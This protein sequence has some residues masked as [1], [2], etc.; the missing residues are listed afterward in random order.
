MG[1]FMKEQFW[2]WL[3]GLLVANLFFVLACFAWLA[4]GLVGRSVQ[5]DLGLE[6]WY[7]L[8]TPV[9]QPAIGILMA[10]ALISGAS[11]WISQKLQRDPD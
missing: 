5:I 4:I 9:M 1:G 3:N 10:G 7:K 8:W 6:L 11:S 2:R